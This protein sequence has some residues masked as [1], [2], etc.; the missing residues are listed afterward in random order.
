MTVPIGQISVISSK[1]QQIR[2]NLEKAITENDPEKIEGFI[3]RIGEH[4]TV[5]QENVVKYKTTLLDQA[6]EKMYS[7]LLEKNKS[8]DEVVLKTTTLAKINKDA[9]TF[10]YLHGEGDKIRSDLQTHLEKMVELNTEAAKKP[11][12]PTLQQ[13]TV[14]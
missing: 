3:K 11:P 9:E 2:V 10:A 14:L 6:D 4:N 7:E 13:Q 1:F 5:M 12:T 8:F